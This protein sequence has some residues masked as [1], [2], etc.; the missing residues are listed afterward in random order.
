MNNSMKKNILLLA[1][2]CFYSLTLTAQDSLSL[3]QCIKYATLHNR[4]LQNAAL[5][6][7]S[8]AELRKEMRA[9]YFPEI[10][11]NVMAFYAFDKII[12]ADGFYPEELASLEQINPAFAQL[13]G[14]PY[15]LHELN[16]SFAATLS[17]MQPI[18]AGGQIKNANRMAGIE[19]EIKALQF[20]MKEKD[21]IQKVT[22]NYWQIARL[23]YN[24]LTISAAQKQLKAVY[25]KV[26][27]FVE[28]GI[29][30]RNALLK[31]KLRRQ[32][33]SSNRLQLEN[34]IHILTMLLAQQIGLGDA[35]LHLSF[36]DVDSSYCIP[37]Y[38]DSHTASS[39]REEC[40]LASKAME[41]HKIQIKLEQ[42]KNLPTLAAG[43]MCYHTSLGGLSATIKNN[44]NT[45]MTNAMGL[46]SLSIPIS[47]WFGGSHAIKRAK[48]KYAQSLNDYQDI[49]EKLIIDTESA[50]S[51][52]QE[53]YKQIEIARASVEEANENLRMETDQYTVGK[54]TISDLLDAETINRQAQG[55]LSSA[56]ATFNIRYADYQRKIK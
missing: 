41:A 44:L 4:T 39:E 35:P 55:Q 30:T 23:N 5:D 34:A 29:A 46:V 28:T 52:L 7:K 9:K 8:S 6:I 45:S 49:K 26:N 42:G 40:R 24:L 50:W 37:T 33:L 25:E 43:F 20:S 38:S 17:I 22:E 10:S 21:V 14:K 18:Y 12:K 1:C 11:A 13:A 15:S 51:S 16:S 3:E 19:A 31:V 48:I 54:N 53:S 36:P 56:I 27:N 2:L 32:E 47:S